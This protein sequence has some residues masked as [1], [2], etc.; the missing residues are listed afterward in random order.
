MLLEYD[1]QRP[2]V[3]GLSAIYAFH[4]VNFLR[5][6]FTKFQWGTETHGVKLCY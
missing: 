3:Y 6:P 1:L 2:T 5:T 4:I